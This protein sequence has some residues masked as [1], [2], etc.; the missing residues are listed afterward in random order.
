[1]IHT[2]KLLEGAVIT[3]RAEINAARDANKPKTMR[4]AQTRF[5]DYLETLEMLKLRRAEA[6]RKTVSQKTEDR[7]EDASAEG[8]AA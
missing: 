6:R 7:R 8:G 1:M 4:Q 2:I 3:T 5:L